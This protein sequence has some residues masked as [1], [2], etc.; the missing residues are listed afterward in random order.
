MKPI[1]AFVPNAGNQAV[2]GSLDQLRGCD[3]V[4]RS[5]VLSGGGHN[6]VPADIETIHVDSLTSSQAIAQLAARATTPLLLL[7]L[8]DTS[9]QIAPYGIERNGDIAQS[10]G[11]ALVYSDF[12]VRKNETRTPHPLL[13]YQ[14]G[15]IRDDFNFGSIVML[16]TALVKKWAALIE[17]ENYRYAGL[18]ALRLALSP[19]RRSRADS[20]D[21]L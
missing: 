10:T 20:G 17:K 3:L 13:D 18:Y 19:R 12:S 6:H 7:V 8:H 15:S 11:A 1:T 4:E 5:Y 2:L 16:N 21:A 9:L 14:L